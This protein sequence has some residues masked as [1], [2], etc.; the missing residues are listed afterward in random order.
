[1]QTPFPKSR[2]ITYKKR[3]VPIYYELE[4]NLMDELG[5]DFSGL[6]KEAIKRLHNSRQS[7]KLQ[8]V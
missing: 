7:A 5:L 6:H 3:E 1:M 4:Q 8:M 2:H